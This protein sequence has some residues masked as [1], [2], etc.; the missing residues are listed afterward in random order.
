MKKILHTHFIELPMFD[1]LPNGE[2][3]ITKVF[4]LVDGTAIVE[5]VTKSGVIYKNKSAE[6]FNKLIER[7]HNKKMSYLDMMDLFE[8][9]EIEA[10]FT[11]GNKKTAQ[12]VAMDDVRIIV[13]E[14]FNII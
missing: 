8:K 10:T 11:K 1:H 5:T 13:E 2:K 3:V 9:S 4:E 14:I 6:E 12:V 7:P